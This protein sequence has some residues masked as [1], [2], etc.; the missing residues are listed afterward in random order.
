[1]HECQK[2]VL[3]TGIHSIFFQLNHDGVLWISPTIPS[4]RTGVGS[5][6]NTIDYVLH[7]PE[8]LRPAT[9]NHPP[10]SVL[11]S[12]SNLIRTLQSL[13]GMVWGRG[14][15]SLLPRVR[16]T[17]PIRPRD[18]SHIR[19]RDHNYAAELARAWACRGGSLSALSV[20][21]NNHAT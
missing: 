13:P 2:A 16:R 4:N 18:P 14:L 15:R 6:W 19:P 21:K 3:N 7:L 10:F 12:K 17:G 8:A 1:V 9:G 11:K 20:L 5:V